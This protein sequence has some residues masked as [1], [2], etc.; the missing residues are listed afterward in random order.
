MT[1]KEGTDFRKEDEMG[2]KAYADII[3]SV[4]GLV[5]LE[6]GFETS[7]KVA[8]EL[9][10]TVPWSESEHLPSGFEESPGLSEAI[11]NCTGY[12]KFRRKELIIEA[13][14]HP[15]ALSTEVSSYQRLEWIGD[16]VLCI[17]VRK[18][19]YEN[20]KEITLGEMVVIEAAVVSN[21]TLA[22]LAVRYGL[23]HHLDHRD[24]SLPSRIEAY[25][26]GV[27][28]YGT[29]LWGTDPPKSISDMAEAII[30]SVHVDGGFVEGQTACLQFMS[31]VL[32]VLLKARKKN[33][34]IC[35]KH[36]R[37]IMQEMGGELLELNVNRESDLV[38]S[39]GGT[40]IS[41]PGG[42]WGQASRDGSSHVAS[43][44]ILGSIVAGV[45]NP[46][47]TVAKNKVCA[48]TVCTL[49]ANPGLRDRLQTCRSRIKS[50][51]TCHLKAL[52]EK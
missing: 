44:S 12:R 32:N 51:Q 28:E 27:R 52:T 26:S 22:F 6:C 37:K 16:A 19:I 17:A 47:A 48:L 18:W 20:F 49:E 33:K 24:Y 13:F 10:V 5:F 23:Q 7:M 9:R 46:S 39:E 4:L 3:E 11:S 38:I 1:F 25:T 45:S 2:P 35:F 30:G 31:P 8:D 29:G 50:G 36:P 21:E 14:T 43:V 15:S 42:K 34:D 40:E 41:F